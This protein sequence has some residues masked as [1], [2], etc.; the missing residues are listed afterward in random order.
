MCVFV[1]ECVMHIHFSFRETN[2][3]ERETDRH[4]E[5]R[6][7]SGIVATSPL[8]NKL[9]P[10]LD[11]LTLLRA[12]NRFYI[13]LRVVVACVFMDLQCTQP[14]IHI[15]FSGDFYFFYFL[16]FIQFMQNSALYK[17]CIELHTHIHIIHIN[18]LL[19]YEAEN[20]IFLRKSIMCQFGRFLVG[21]FFLSIF[22]QSS[23]YTKFEINR[24]RNERII[25]SGNVQ[26]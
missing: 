5:S 11:L 26:T 6:I 24:V 17:V 7:A 12:E 16:Q 14:L 8:R 2:Q 20:S 25:V 1:C 22:A 15:K 21:F 13:A 3:I 10:N 9:S 4:R 23:K 19:V 18:S